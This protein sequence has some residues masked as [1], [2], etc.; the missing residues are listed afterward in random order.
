M[1]QK[2]CCLRFKTKNSTSET[3]YLLW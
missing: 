2:I 1:I 3:N